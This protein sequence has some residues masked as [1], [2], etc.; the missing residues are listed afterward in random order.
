MYR[1]SVLLIICTTATITRT[2]MLRIVQSESIDCSALNNPTQE[3]KKSIKTASV[4]VIIKKLMLLAFVFV[5]L[6]LESSLLLFLF[7][8]GFYLYLFCWLFASLVILCYG[9]YYLYGYY[10]FFV[11][12][13]N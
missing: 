10:Y 7:L 13:S 6:F 11:C 9:Y 5:C 4:L 2:P 8:R 1:F 3:I 12:Y